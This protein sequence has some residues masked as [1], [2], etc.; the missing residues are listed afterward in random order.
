MTKKTRAI[1]FLL[2][3]ILLIYIFNQIKKFDPYNEN[4]SDDIK[5]FSS[6][7]ENKPTRI[8]L[9]IVS[10][11]FD[12]LRG[13][14]PKEYYFKRINETAKLNAPFVFFTQAKFKQDIQKLFPKNKSLKIITL[15]LEDLFYYQDI[16]VIRHIQSLKIYR[17][18]ITAPNRIECVNPFYIIVQFSKFE[19]LLKSAQKNYFNSEKFLWIDAGI[20]RWW[21][22]FNAS[23]K[24]T[25]KA[26]PNNKF[27][28]T[29]EKT[30][31]KDKLFIRKDYNILW[32]QRSYVLGGVLGGT[33]EAILKVAKKMRKKW[34]WMLYE[35]NIVQNEQFALLIEFFENP[36]L[37]HFKEVL[38][39]KYF[40]QVFNY[41]K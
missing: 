32:K 25:A 9:T 16:R 11:Y 30:R 20:N 23:S 36:S 27:Y 34:R 3:I 10:A 35:Q 8:P 14:R 31:L 26:I 12:I 33:L 29:L 19:F 1:L 2:V 22:R 38:S 28:F 39:A 6:S 18:K 41:L 5:E 15:D 40:E 17:K 37:F 24:L 7:S 13:E 21:G 4:Q